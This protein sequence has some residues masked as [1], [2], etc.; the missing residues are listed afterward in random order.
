MIFESL[1]SIENK[2]KKLGF[3][4]IDKNELIVQ[5]QRKN[6]QFNFIHGVD[7]VHKRSGKHIIQSFQNDSP[8]F[9]FDYMVGLTFEETELFLKYAK[10]LKW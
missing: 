9:G 5:F 7:I 1:K 4:I 8:V 6:K 3:K 10:K 2:I